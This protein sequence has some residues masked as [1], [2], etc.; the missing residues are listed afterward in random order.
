MPPFLVPGLS[1]QEASDICMNRCRA[2]CCRGPLLLEL[3]PDEVEDFLANGERLQVK[4]K[5]NRGVNNGA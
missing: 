1:E 5:A 2:M 3:G 4:V